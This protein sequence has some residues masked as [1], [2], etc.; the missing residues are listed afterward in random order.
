MKKI[1]LLIIFLVLIAL[2]TKTIHAQRLLPQ[3]K[4]MSQTS[5]GTI[6]PNGITVYVRLRND[7]NA[8]LFTLGNLSVVKTVSYNLF[9]IT[10]GKEEGAGGTVAVQDIKTVSRE[11]LFGTCS[12]KVCKYHTNITNMKFE[13][14][15]T[16][17]TGRKTIRRYKIKI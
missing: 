11:L 7:R 9:Y 1:Y 16:L 10:N 17:L 12:A 15:T 5:S 13:V 14:E 2:F 6:K 4:N 3:A 8:L